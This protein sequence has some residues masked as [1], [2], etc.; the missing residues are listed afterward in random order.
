MA[1]H[2]NVPVAAFALSISSG[3]IVFIIGALLSIIGTILTLPIGGIGGIIG[4][5]GLLWGLLI[6][7]SALLMYFRPNEH[8]MWGIL[9]LVF[10]FLSWIGTLGGL[11]IGFILGLV[12]GTLAI[13]WN[14]GGWSS[15]MT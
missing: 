8:V 14:P 11:V 7:I 15:Q 6:I 12:G 1:N 13:I 2:R 4:Y 3:I 5:F 10:S 9:V